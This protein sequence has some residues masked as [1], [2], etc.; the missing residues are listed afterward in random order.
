MDRYRRALVACA[1]ATLVQGASAA[2]GF[3]VSPLRLE[4]S[5]AKP[6]ASFTLTNSGD[7]PVVIQ[8]QPRQ[9]RQ[10]DGQDVHEATRALLVNP[11]IVSLKPGESQVVRVALRGAADAERETGFRMFFTEVPQAAPTDAAPA[12]G[13]NIRIVKRM[14]V[15][16]FVA[17]VA[18]QAKPAGELRASAAG[19]SLRLD[20]GNSGTA[21]W[22]LGELEVLDARTGEPFG[23]P[24]VVSVLPGG[25]RRIVLPM[26]GRAVPASI[27]VKAD[28]GGHPYRAEVEVQSPR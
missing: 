8:A 27:A 12:G 10:V 13:M 16:V 11:A 15:P 26:R 7:T 19:A 2:S 22:R 1:L 25:M 6:M 21:H 17:P 28:A 23:N 14:D 18:G 5:A 4:L 3:G 9:W 20:F 24:T